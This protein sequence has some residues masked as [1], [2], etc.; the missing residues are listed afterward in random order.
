VFVALVSGQHFD[1][2]LVAVVLDRK[3]WVPELPVPVL[4]LLL[5][6]EHSKWVSVESNK[7]CSNGS[8]KL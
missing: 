3:L 7:I 4:H 2:H 5:Q 1:L 8:L 6:F